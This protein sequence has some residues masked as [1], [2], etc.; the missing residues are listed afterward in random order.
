MNADVEVGEDSLRF[1][2]FDSPPEIPEGKGLE[3]VNI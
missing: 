1:V 3:E 2:N